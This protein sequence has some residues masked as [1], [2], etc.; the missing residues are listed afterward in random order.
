LKTEV[1]T[2]PARASTADVTPRAAR[3]KAAAGK[4]GGG[5]DRGANS[6]SARGARGATSSAHAVQIA[7]WRHGCVRAHRRCA[8]GAAWPEI[9]PSTA[10]IAE[11]GKN[12]ST[13]EIERSF[14][15]HWIVGYSD[16]AGR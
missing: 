1:G 10:R 7:R 13:L 16:L 6:G 15:G 8:A 12:P 4:H 2:S 14:G 5:R 11:T 3:R 9:S